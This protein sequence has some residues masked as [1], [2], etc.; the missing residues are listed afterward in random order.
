MHS[1]GTL[2]YLNAVSNGFNEIKEPY[3][4]IAFAAPYLE[5]IEE[6]TATELL[7]FHSKFKPLTASVPEIL[8][9]VSLQKSAHKQIRYFSSG[10]KQRLKLAQA[11]YSKSDLLLLDEPITNLDQE[12]IELYRNLLENQAKGKTIIVSSN[13]KQEYDFCNENISILSY[14]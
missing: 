11:F 2:S 4:Q 12:G 13:D 14:K 8:A 1:E 5:L 9:D 6:M 10:M 7:D 3:K